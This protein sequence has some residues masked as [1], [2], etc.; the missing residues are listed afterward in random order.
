MK[1]RPLSL[2]PPRTHTHTHTHTRTHTHTHTHTHT[3]S[4]HTRTHTRS[5]LTML[6]V[7]SRPMQA[8]AVRVPRKRPAARLGQ[9]YRKLR[10]SRPA[11][12]H[13]VGEGQRSRIPRRPQPRYDIRRVGRRRVRVKPPCGTTVRWI[14]QRGYHGVGADCGTV[15]GPVSHCCRAPVCDA[16]CIDGMRGRVW[17]S[18]ALLACAQRNRSREAS[19]AV[20]WFVA[21]LGTN[22]EP[23]RITSPLT[24]R[25]LSHHEPS[26]IMSH[27][28]S[29]ALSQYGPSH[30]MSLLAS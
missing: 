12:G 24:S 8:G 2:H 9:L 30:I 14:V 10:A 7:H 3:R 13:G 29:R 17:L 5:Q 11:C 16:C 27:L 4:R 1:P 15:G 18:S 20:P 6:V 22:G 28:A 23:S 25:A 21:R 26:R 19:P